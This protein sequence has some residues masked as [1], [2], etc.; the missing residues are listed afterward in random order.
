MRWDSIFYFKFLNKLRFGFS[1]FFL[2]MLLLSV[3]FYVFQSHE[4]LSLF[5]ANFG[6]TKRLFLMICP[7]FLLCLCYAYI[8]KQNNPLFILFILILL[9][10]LVVLFF[11]NLGVELLSILFLIIYIGA[12]AVLFLFVIM[13]FDVRRMPQ[14]M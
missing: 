6:A 10:L 11:F 8:L 9:V 13:L 1:L 2:S 3:T 7:L 12:I 4:Y 14:Y 5:I